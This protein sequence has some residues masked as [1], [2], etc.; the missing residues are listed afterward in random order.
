MGKT[1]TVTDVNSED[2]DILWPKVKGY[3]QSAVDKNQ[4]EFTLTDV[5]EGLRANEMRLWIAYNA[6]GEL[7]ASAV[8]ELLVYPNHKICFI[9]L[10]GGHDFSLW[11]YTIAAIEDWALENGAD[12]V[13]AY[14]RKGF[15]KLM[16]A[17]DYEEIYTVISKKLSERRIH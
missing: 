9:K 17:Y 16:K 7:L 3:L 2:V 15:G 4:D 10:L 5:L 8:C 13:T 11:S 12:R 6:E 1:I 14:T